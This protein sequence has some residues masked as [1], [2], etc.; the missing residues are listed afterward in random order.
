MSGIPFD[1]LELLAL[2]FMDYL[3]HL[4]FRQK[5]GYKLLELVV[6]AWCIWFNRN[7]VRQGKAPQTSYDIL[8]KARYLLAEFHIANLKLSQAML[9]DEVHRTPPDDPWYKVNV[10]V[11][12]FSNSKSIGVRAL[13]HDQGGCVEAAISKSLPFLLGPLEAEAKSLEESVFFA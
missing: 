10:D 2:D 6:V 4:K 12:L 11:A 13:I 9:K 8:S 1:P 5:I 3:W 7:E